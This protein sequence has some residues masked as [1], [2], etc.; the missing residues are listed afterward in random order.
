MVCQG[1]V[2]GL[3]LVE[4]GDTPP[5]QRGDNLKGKTMT[6]ATRNTVEEWA[7]TVSSGEALGEA[8]GLTPCGVL[9]VMFPAIVG[10]DDVMGAL[11]SIVEHVAQPVADLERHGILPVGGAEEVLHDLFHLIQIAAG[12]GHMVGVQ[13]VM[14]MTASGEIPDVDDPDVFLSLFGSP[15]VDDDGGAEDKGND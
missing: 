12:L 13:D 10:D 9:H 7:R 11:A 3:Q 15:D 8:L 1:I 14:A 4:S 6:T 2:S 5:D